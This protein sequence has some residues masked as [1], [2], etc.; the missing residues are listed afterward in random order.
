MSARE[1]RVL[2][3]LN[4]PAFQQNLFTLQAGDQHAVLGTLRR[5][6]QMSWDQ[7]YRDRGLRW[8]LIHSRVGPHGRRIYSLR[9]SRGCRA[10]AYREGSWL[11]LLSLHP[12]HDSAYTG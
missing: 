9:I 3:D 2:L 4:S 12:D 1:E 7:V 11:V 10:T 8:E 5:L 6:S